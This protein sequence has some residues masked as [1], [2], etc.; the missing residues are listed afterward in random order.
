MNLPI[1]DP[2]P[3]EEKAVFKAL[4]NTFRTFS[5]L[6]YIAEPPQAATRAGS[7]LKQPSK[8]L[9]TTSV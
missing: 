5:I 6:G 1:A 4:E 8:F 2:P 9:G 7:N 3:P